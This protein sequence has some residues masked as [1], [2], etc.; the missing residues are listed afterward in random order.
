MD[1]F[2]DVTQQ[3]T[4]WQQV[5]IVF[6]CLFFFYFDE[7]RNTRFCDKNMTKK[8]FHPLSSHRGLASVAPKGN[9]RQRTGAIVPQSG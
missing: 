9:H 8:I 6:S 1:S 5:H 7:F 2:R 4:F 3:E